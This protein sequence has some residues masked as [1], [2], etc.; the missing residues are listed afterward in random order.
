MTAAIAKIR[1][2]GNSRGILFSKAI[3][4]ESGIRN[5]VKISVENSIIM[6]SSAD[7]PAKKKWSDFKK[8]RKIKSDFVVNRFD[9]TEWTW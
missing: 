2:I 7:K 6:I 5:T 4:E 1:K 9:E 3:L 8:V